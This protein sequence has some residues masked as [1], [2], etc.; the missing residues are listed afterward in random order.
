MLEAKPAPEFWARFDTAPDP[1]R[2]FREAIERELPGFAHY[3][4][5]MTIEPRFQG[6]RYGVTSFIPDEIAQTLF[7]G[8]PEHHLLLLIDKAGLFEDG[9][10]W[11]GDAEDLKEH[12]CREASPARGS[13]LRLLGACPTACGQHLARL[14]VKFPARIEK[15]R[16]GQRRDW[17]IHRPPA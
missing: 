16:T 12:L 1:R 3:L 10:P 11:E 13:A 6:R 17:I 2:A 4:L 14:K 7:E 15:H 9:K 5:S 8:E